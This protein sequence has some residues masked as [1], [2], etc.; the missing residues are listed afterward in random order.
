MYQM[1]SRYSLPPE[2][3]QTVLE[4]LSAS[5]RYENLASRTPIRSRHAFSLVSRRFRELARPHI[6]HT[7]LI[8]SVNPRPG[9]EFSEFLEFL[10]SSPHIAHYVQRPHLSGDTETVFEKMIMTQD[11]LVLDVLAEILQR[12]PG[13]RRLE[14]NQLAL[15]STSMAPFPAPIL[16]HLAELTLNLDIDHNVRSFDSDAIWFPGALF[17]LLSLFSEIGNLTVSSLKEEPCKCVD[18]GS[19]DTEENVAT[20]LRLHFPQP[21]S[22]KSVRIERIDPFSVSQVWSTKILAEA[23]FTVIRRYQI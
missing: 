23:P 9:G 16:A 19:E 4:Y 6:F 14:L 12:L 17:R 2:L 1:A 7:M 21:L 11:W 13:L 10:V 20:V 8:T 15:V 3:W 5:D 18:T 22:L